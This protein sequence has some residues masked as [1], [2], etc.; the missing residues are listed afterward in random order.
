MNDLPGFG[1][2]LARLLDRRG[3]DAPGLS[4]L[5]GVPEDKVQALLDGAGPDPSL[6]PALARALGLHSADLFVIAW[7]PVPDEL[8]PFDR[9]A[10]GLI[11][12]LANEAT[13]LSAQSLTELR[14]FT[15]SL[16]QLSRTSPPQ[17]GPDWLRYERSFGAMIVAMLANRNLFSWAGAAQALA[18]LTPLYWSP[19]T[20]GM[21]GRGRKILTPDELACFAQ[22]LDIPLGDLTAIGDVWLP[23]EKLSQ[24]GAGSE[25]ARLLWDVRHLTAD[26]LHKVTALAK[27]MREDVVAHEL[28]ARWRR[29]VQSSRT[30]GREAGKDPISERAARHVAAFNDSVRSGDWAA[31]A[32]RFTSDATMRFIGVPVGPFTG[33]E[34]IAAGY[35]TQPPSDTLTVTRAVAS[36]D[37]D[38]LWFAWDSGGTGEMTLHWRDGLIAELTVAFS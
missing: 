34:A 26:Q 4:G 21:V 24:D 22:L 20:V 12:G 15:R 9:S 25:M 5:S 14:A 38:R 3:L 19:A 29:L 11:Q 8:R 27:S 2:L 23:P 6:L 33:R 13:R 17:W 16:P 28:E 37:I 36:G 30:V 7:V 31:F 32:D 35:A 1:I 10:G 18:R